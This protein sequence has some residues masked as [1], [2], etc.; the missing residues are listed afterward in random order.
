MTVRN[1]KRDLAHIH[2][3][4]VIAIEDRGRNILVSLN[5]INLAVS[6]R[7]C[8]HSQFRYRAASI[9]FAPD[10]CEQELPKLVTRERSGP[11]P[12]RTGMVTPVRNRFD[13]LSVDE[14]GD[15]GDEANSSGGEGRS[16]TFL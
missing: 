9:T 11:L 13:L 14:S 12:E 1:I 3:L 5:A 7:T 16:T 8:L 15:A 2:Q 6:A 4:E 10:D